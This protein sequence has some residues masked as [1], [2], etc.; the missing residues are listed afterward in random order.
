M[1]RSSAFSYRC[2]CCGLCCR[3]KVITL[4]PYDVMRMAAAAGRGT[5]EVV[6][7]YTLRR[8]SL[9]RFAG[10]GAC[11]ALRNGLCAIHSG[12]PL[13]CRLYPLGMERI[14]DGERFVRL[15]PALGSIGI[16]GEDGTVN[17][18]VKQQ[19]VEPYLS[20]LQSYAVLL[21]LMR[22]RIAQLVDFEKTDP[23]EFRR[24]AVRE[25]LAESGYDYNPLI[26]AMFDSDPWSGFEQDGIRSP[27]R[28]VSALRERIQAQTDAPPL[29]AA[30]VMLAVSIGYTP[31]DV[32]A[33][34]LSPYGS[35]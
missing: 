10:D 30:A 23:A 27:A 17:G 1:D 15:E 18:F 11:I 8:G 29:A 7:R 25:A 4:A 28:H 16:Y 26:D 20:A 5:A 33:D 32:F 12:R 3:D 2:G 19:G 13:P 9:L 14:G 35:R 34:L 6:A 31:A 21:P 22:T 24:V